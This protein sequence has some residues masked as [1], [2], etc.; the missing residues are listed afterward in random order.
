MLVA[1]R[2]SFPSRGWKQPEPGA[3]KALFL[4]LAAHSLLVLMFTVGLNWRTSSTPAGVEVELWD[5]PVPTRQIEPEPMVEKPIINKDDKAEIVTKKK[6]EEPKPE[7][8]KVEKKPTTPPLTLKPIEKPIEKPKQKPEPPK[9]EPSKLKDSPKA[10]P[11]SDPAKEAKAN[12]DAEKDRLDRIEKLRA[13]AGAEGGGSGGSVGS[14]V[15]SGGND[16]PGFADKVRK[17]IKPK[18]T[19]NP[20]GVVGNPAVTIQVELA[21]DGR[22]MN[23]KMVKS[24]GL[25]E[26]DN[27]VLRALE[28]AGSLPKDDNGSVPRQIQLI[29]RPKD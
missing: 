29:F 14:G 16:A 12:A 20:A 2:T 25:S 7:K 5:A 19:F 8:P 1:S 22:I 3:K 28:F 24:S 13:Q 9:V 21:P 11:T 4:S 15:G 18:I 6:K 23:Q 26:W 17:F 10:K 27:A